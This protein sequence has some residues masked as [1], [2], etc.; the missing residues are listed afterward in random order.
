MT[1]HL[2]SLNR[3]AA[4]VNMNNVVV[5]DAKCVEQTSEDGENSLYV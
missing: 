2:F 3:I 1:G 4:A 5:M